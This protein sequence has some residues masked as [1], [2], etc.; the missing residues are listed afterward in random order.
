MPKTIY[1]K[2]DIILA[3]RNFYNEYNR[4]PMQKDFVKNPNYP[5]KNTVV[6]FF[7]TWNNG[8]LAAGLKTSDWSD[9]DLISALVNF[10]KDNGQVPAYN[11]FVGNFPSA[12]TIETRFGSWNNAMEKAGFTTVTKY[13]KRWSNRDILESI[14]S[15]YKEHNRIPECREF[16]LSEQ[17]PNY[18]TV[19]TRFKSWNVAI[20]EAGFKPNTQNSLGTNTT[21]KDGHIYRS[22]AEATFVDKF[23]F[24]KYQ[25]IIEPKYPEPYIRYYDWYVNDL[26]IYIELD[27]GIRPNITK[28]KININKKLHR[29][30][31]FIP[32]KAIDI[33]RTIEELK[34]KFI[35]DYS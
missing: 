16:E 2:E 23:L 11:N 30:C 28:E 24:N 21:A 25:Y 22:K 15:F 12:R 34:N 14:Q 1:T 29:C 20:E 3:I 26:N 32:I 31:L 9:E 13:N 4:I 10:Y 33:Y 27:G 35:L 17:Y 8:I 18:R 7:G 6:R 5:G 19:A